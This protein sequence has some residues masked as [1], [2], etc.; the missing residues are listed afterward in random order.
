[1]KSKS[2]AI[3][4]PTSIVIFATSA[5][6]LAALVPAVAVAGGGSNGNG[7]TEKPIDDG[8]Q[9]KPEVNPPLKAG[10]AGDLLGAKKSDGD[11]G[12]S[13]GNNGG[14][15]GGGGT[16]KDTDDSAGGGGTR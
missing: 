4:R 10:A 15:N 16:H 14:S 12:N 5:V 8:G 13:G 7:G 2:I 1:M 3:R 9:L 6:C 11:S